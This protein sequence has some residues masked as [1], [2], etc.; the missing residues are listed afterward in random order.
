MG[1]Q[2]GLSRLGDG[3]RCSAQ[4]GPCRRVTQSGQRGRRRYPAPGELSQEGSGSEKAQGNQRGRVPGSRGGTQEPLAK[5]PSSL[6]ARTGELVAEELAFARQ[7]GTRG[8]HWT[9]TGFALQDGT[10]DFFLD[11]ALTRCSCSIH[12]APA[13]PCRHAA[14]PR[15]LLTGQPYSTWTCS[16]IA[17]EGPEP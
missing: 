3:V 12:A 2:E 17:G 8:F 15:R 9:G 10:S 7:H 1:T 5:S 4:E 6:R 13:Q 11:G 14:P 16:G